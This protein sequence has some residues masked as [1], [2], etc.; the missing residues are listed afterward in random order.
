MGRGSGRTSRQARC[1]SLCCRRLANW[2]VSPSMTIAALILLL[3]MAATMQ[4]P[5]PVCLPRVQLRLVHPR[6]IASESALRMARSAC[7]SGTNAP[8]ELLSA[9]SCPRDCLYM[10][11]SACKYHYRMCVLTEVADRGRKLVGFGSEF[12]YNRRVLPVRPNVAPRTKLNQLTSSSSANVPSPRSLRMRVVRVTFA[13][14]CQSRHAGG[15]R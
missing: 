10:G 14:A 9:G 13:D 8:E 3:M 1:G 12:R 7:S 11:V 2:W 4:N 5:L 15:K 6:G